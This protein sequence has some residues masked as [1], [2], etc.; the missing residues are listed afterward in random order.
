MLVDNGEEALDY[1][2]RKG[3]YA[4]PALSP[5]PDL[6]LLDLNLPKIDGHQ[7]LVQMRADRELSRIPVVVLTTS[8]HEKD[9]LRCYDAGCNAYVQKP[10]DLDDLSRLAQVLVDHWFKTVIGP[11]N[12]S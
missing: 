11:P 3:R 9:V 12:P 4:D 1:L 8:Q 6:V 10:L 7:V 5:R 2:Q